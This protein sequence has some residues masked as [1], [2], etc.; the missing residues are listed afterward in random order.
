MPE[1]EHQS[2]SEEEV[3]ATDETTKVL[4][5]RL[6][7]KH[8]SRTG[9]D[10]VVNS[11]PVTA[12]VDT[13]ATDTMIDQEV[14]RMLHVTF[15]PQTM[16]VQAAFGNETE[17]L[18][19]SWWSY[20]WFGEVKTMRA[21]VC[22]ELKQAV[23]LGNSF[24]RENQIRVN[25]SERALEIAEDG[26]LRTVSPGELEFV[27]FS[28]PPNNAVSTNKMYD[29]V[30]HIG[31]P[32][33]EETTAQGTRGPGR[34][35]AQVGEQEVLHGFKIRDTDRVTRVKMKTKANIK[36][37][38][39]STNASEVVTRIT[40][41]DADDEKDS[42]DEIAIH[43][44]YQIKASKRETR[45]Q[46]KVYNDVVVADFDDRTDFQNLFAIP[47]D[48][49]R[50]H[51]RRLEETLWRN[52]QVFS[53][54]DYDVSITSELEMEVETVPNL[55]MVFKKQ[56][57]RR[58]SPQDVESI[59]KWADQMVSAGFL[60]PSKSTISS[61]VHVV[62]K[63]GKKDRPVCDFREIG[64]H[65]KVPDFPYVCIRDIFDRLSGAK[66]F[67]VVDM[68][69][70]FYAIRVRERDRWKLAIRTPRRL[71]EFCSCPMGLQTS[72]LY[73][74]QLSFRITAGQTNILSYVDDLIVFSDTIE[75]H[76]QHF[77]TLLRR[78]S[79]VNVKIKPSKC[80]LFRT[81]IT[82][83]GHEV[84]ANGLEIPKDRIQSIMDL[85]NPKNHKEMMQMIGLF[86][87]V[88]DFIVDFKDDKKALLD[89]LKEKKFV[90][91]EEAK[92]A[93][94]SL[95]KK[96]TRPPCLGIPDE[97]LTKIIQVDSSQYA[98]GG[99]NRSSG[100]PEEERSSN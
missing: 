94:E 28:S 75:E 23:L 1:P 22:P 36:K 90:L 80:Q 77:E 78:L 20:K 89:C 86:G 26:R 96:L 27:S 42:E 47:E 18:G 9:I 76:F 38:S 24:L 19:L 49:D 37:K 50:E 45:S 4:T 68:T 99:I 61:P 88:S 84:S 56:G 91:T 7:K 93:I 82:L 10:I 81:R 95:K 57:I 8:E 40:C 64:R 39:I 35:G 65:I 73:L 55:E 43:E 17:A 31:W 58:Y 54:H 66:I 100:R 87:W 34:S 13:G 74:Q 5:V 63:D 29:S 21:V 30:P 48:M 62:R 79:E 92:Q 85:P 69:Q 3:C 25:P 59:E 12:L 2:P 41:G 71:L 33:D 11:V 44:C 16:I 15:E 32:S 14:A 46:S 97:K 67:S 53:R 51:R 60:R 6:K 52:K 72:P 83:L 70:S 98:V